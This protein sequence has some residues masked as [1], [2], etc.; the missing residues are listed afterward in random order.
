VK[1]VA[2]PQSGLAAAAGVGSTILEVWDGARYQRFSANAWPCA[3]EGRVFAGGWQ[4]NRT[5]TDPQFLKVCDPLAAI[6]DRRTQGL[7]AEG[8]EADARC[9]GGSA[10]TEGALAERVAAGTAGS[11]AQGRRRLLCAGER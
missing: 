6:Q 8:G 1:T 10:G 5:E 3:M 9:N 2:T 7:A 4:R 11:E